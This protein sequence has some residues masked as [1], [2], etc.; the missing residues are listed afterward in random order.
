MTQEIKQN[1]RYTL[2]GPV[3]GGYDWWAINDFGAD[4]RKLIL[5]REA[6]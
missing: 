4:G 1:G 5:L 3:P 6:N 2:V